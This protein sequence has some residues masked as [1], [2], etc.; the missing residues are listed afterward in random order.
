MIRNYFIIAI[1]R[2]S[3]QFSYTF[4]NVV[5]L[6]VGVA[7]FLLIMMYIQFHLGFDHHIPDIDQLYRVV[8][9]QQA[10]GVGE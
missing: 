3:K 5:G 1:R 7:S 2:L 10:E 8:Q 4:I 9:I 6:S